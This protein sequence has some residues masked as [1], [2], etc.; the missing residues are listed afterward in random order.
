MAARVATAS[1]AAA[2]AAAI[3]HLKHTRAAIGRPADRQ[4]AHPADRRIRAGFFSSL[5]YISQYGKNF[6]VVKNHAARHNPRDCRIGKC[7][8]YLETTHASH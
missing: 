8:S 4:P 3:R 2:R 6:C 1:A 5:P 7:I